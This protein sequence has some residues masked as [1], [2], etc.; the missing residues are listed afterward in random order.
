MNGSQ[1]KYVFTL[2]INDHIAE[3]DSSLSLQEPYYAKKL[4]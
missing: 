3:A 1:I 4:S 2:H